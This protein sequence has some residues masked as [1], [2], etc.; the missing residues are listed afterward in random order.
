MAGG[1]DGCAEG[2]NGGGGRRG[3]RRGRMTGGGNKE[4]KRPL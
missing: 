2:E 4:G 3:Q 1:A